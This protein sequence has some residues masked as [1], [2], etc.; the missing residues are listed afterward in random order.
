MKVMRI[1]VKLT[2]EVFFESRVGIILINLTP[3]N[4]RNPCWITCGKTGF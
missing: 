1:V 3:Y 4:F 2:K